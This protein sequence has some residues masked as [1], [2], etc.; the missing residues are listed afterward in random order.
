VG[1]CQGIKLSFIGGVGSGTP[2]APPGLSQPGLGSF[3]NGL[4]KST[5]NQGGG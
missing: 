3:G 2:G 4:D 5:M 1:R